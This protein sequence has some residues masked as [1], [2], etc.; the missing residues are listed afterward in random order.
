MSQTG[1]KLTW[2]LAWVLAL[3]P[4]ASSTETIIVYR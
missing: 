4:E 3:W 2:A 1:G